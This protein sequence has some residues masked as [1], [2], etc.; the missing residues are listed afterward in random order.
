[1]EPLKVVLLSLIV[2]VFVFQSVAN[3]S[4]EGELKGLFSDALKDVE[5]VLMGQENQNKTQ[6]AGIKQNDDESNRNLF[7]SGR[8]LRRKIAKHFKR[9]IKYILRG[10]FS[11]SKQLIRRGVC[12]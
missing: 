12:G 10:L 6:T 4:E 5:K 1:M 11:K 3:K 2:A 7:R 8:S 9:K